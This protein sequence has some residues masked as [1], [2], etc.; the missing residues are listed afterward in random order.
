MTPTI[1]SPALLVNDAAGQYGPKCFAVAFGEYVADKSES[2][3]ETLE[4]LK[5]GPSHEFYCEAWDEFLASPDCLTPDGRAY[6]VT[7]VDGGIFALPT[8]MSEEEEESFFQ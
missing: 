3:Q 1:D 7:Q 5:S 4:I 6:W 8:D 2:M